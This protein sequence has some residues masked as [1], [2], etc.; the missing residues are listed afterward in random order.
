MAN[1]YDE[2]F[3]YDEPGWR[4]LG[5]RYALIRI[6]LELRSR[7][8]TALELTIVR[9]ELAELKPLAR[10]CLAR[11]AGR[12]LRRELSD[13]EKRGCSG[14]NRGSTLRMQPRMW[15]IIAWRDYQAYLYSSRQPAQEDEERIV[16]RGFTEWYTRMPLFVWLSRLRWKVAPSASARTKSLPDEVLTLICKFTGRDSR[17]LMRMPDGLYLRRAYRLQPRSR[18]RGFQ[19]SNSTSREVRHASPPPRRVVLRSRSA[20]RRTLGRRRG[21]PGA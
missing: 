21:R 17:L 14:C 2:P 9:L 5:D 4:L 12:L 3:V 18:S 10:L 8:R 13:S 16:P 15:T 7:R 19:L 6:D 20:V 1:R 11:E